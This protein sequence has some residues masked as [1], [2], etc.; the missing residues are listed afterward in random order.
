[1][2]SDSGSDSTVPEDDCIVSP[3]V[4]SQIST[5]VSSRENSILICVLF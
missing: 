5:T 2:N 4:S 3:L 1:M